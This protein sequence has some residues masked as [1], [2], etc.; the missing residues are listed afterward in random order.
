MCTLTCHPPPPI[1]CLGSEPHLHRPFGHHTSL[2]AQS[3]CRRRRLLTRS[4]SRQLPALLPC[5][6]QDNEFLDVR[7][8]ER[9]R[10][11]TPATRITQLHPRSYSY[12]SLNGTA[13]L[14]FPPAFR[15]LLAENMAPLAGS[16]GAKSGSR[17]GGLLCRGRPPPS[18]H[19]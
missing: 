13:T 3:C 11:R 2:E 1:P 12:S 15:R 6:V 7:S 16:A 4:R 17:G 18:R 19:A 9:A 8:A 14:V 5:T 10:L